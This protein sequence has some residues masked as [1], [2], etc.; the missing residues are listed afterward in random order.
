[1]TES[2]AARPTHLERMPP[3]ALFLVSAVSQYVGAIIAVRLFERVEPATVA[4]FRVIGAAI[5]LTVVGHSARR[6]WTRTELFAAGLFGSATALMNL[7]FYLGI[8]RLPLGKGVTIEFI[9]PIAVAA[10]TTRSRR[11]AVALGLAV[12]GVAVLSGLELSNEPLGVIFVLL[13]ST[14]WAVYIVVGSRVAALRRGVN[15]LGVGLSIG[16]LVLTPIGIWGS[17]PVWR[18]PELLVLCLA[19]G[20]FSNAIGYGID[21]TVMRRISVRR[22]SVMLALLPVTAVAMGAMFLGQVPT[23]LDLAGIALVLAGVMVQDS[24]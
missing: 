22:F 3:E 9:G 8:D 15:G 5:A 4:W 13:A 20:L 18:S 17:G 12:A 2:S 14:M 16:A 23:P 11:N 21:Q 6:R 7:F 24:S 10:A 19:V 1:V